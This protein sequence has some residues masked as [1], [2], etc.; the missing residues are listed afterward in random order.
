MVSKSVN[1][2]KLV[3]LFSY[4]KYSYI[5]KLKLSKPYFVIPVCKALLHF[6]CDKCSF[7]LKYTSFA[8]PIYCFPLIMFKKLYIP[9]FF[10]R[11]LRLEDM[12]SLSCKSF[13]VIIGMGISTS[14]E[15]KAE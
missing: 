15:L 3:A 6:L 1:N 8:L 12:L 13:M 14:E 7:N 5:Q 11:R 2:L 10:E 4:V 9:P